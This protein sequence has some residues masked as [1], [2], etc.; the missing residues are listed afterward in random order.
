M[1]EIDN[2][3]WIELWPATGGDERAAI[4]DAWLAEQRDALIAAIA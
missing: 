2:P 1:V 4:D 3:V